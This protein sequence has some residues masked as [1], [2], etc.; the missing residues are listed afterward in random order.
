M[1]AFVSWVTDWYSNMYPLTVLHVLDITFT[2]LDRVYY[3]NARLYSV[4]S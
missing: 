1:H 2:L 4:A 3:K